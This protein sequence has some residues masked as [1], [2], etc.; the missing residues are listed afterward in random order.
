MQ[1]KNEFLENGQKE[2]CNG[3]GICVYVCPVGAISMLEDKEGFLYPYINKE[4]CIGC[5]KCKK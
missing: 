3:C 4:K 2:T 5:N 1:M